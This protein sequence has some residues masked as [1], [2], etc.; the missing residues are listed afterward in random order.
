MLGVIDDTRLVDIAATIREKTGSENTYTPAEMASGVNDV[1]EAG[2]EFGMVEWENFILNKRTGFKYLF[3]EADLKGYVFRKTVKPMSKTTYENA[4]MFY[5]YAGTEYPRNIDLS[6]LTDESIRSDGSNARQFF[7]WSTNVEC[8][9]DY[10]IPALNMDTSYTYLRKCHTIE[11]IRIGETNT[12][13][14]FSNTT[15]LVNL[16]FEGVIGKNINVS[17]CT[18]LSHDSLMNIIECLKDYSEDTSGTVYTLIMGSTNI[19]KLTDEEKEII[20]GKGW[21]LK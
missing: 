14:S 16:T 4:R 21:A 19:A 18:K 7:T 8:V 17:P 9:P 20:Y 3:Y 11:K 12:P 2:V 13:P 15:N 10:G 1:Y 6:N 5:S